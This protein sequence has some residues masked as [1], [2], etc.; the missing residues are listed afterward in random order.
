MR[1]GI[2]RLNREVLLRQLNRLV[3]QP[4]NKITHQ[5]F[6]HLFRQVTEETILDSLSQRGGNA[7]RYR[8]YDSP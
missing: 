4:S 7:Q 5:W 1:H 3:T 8:Q 6:A 2:V